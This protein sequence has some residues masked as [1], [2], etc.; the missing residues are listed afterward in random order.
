M[1]RGLGGAIVV[2]DWRTLARG[3]A[4][5][6]RVR[7][8]TNGLTGASGPW[9]PGRLHMQS[10]YSAREA[11]FDFA[12][13][14]GY[15]GKDKRAPARCTSKSPVSW[16]HKCLDLTPKAPSCKRAGHLGEETWQSGSG[17]AV[18]YQQTQ[19]G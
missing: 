14:P 9:R 5:R 17:W 13:A 10:V 1:T 3:L 15:A 2:Q 16:A 8:H 7:R 12:F 18:E 11:N 4:G 19:N 6:W